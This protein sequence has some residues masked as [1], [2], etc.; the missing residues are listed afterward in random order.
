M[1]IQPRSLCLVLTAGVSLLYGVMAYATSDT[2][3]GGTDGV[4]ATALNWVNNG[5]PGTGDTATFSDAGNGNVM[6][7]LGLGVTLATL[8]FDTADAAAYTI[9]TGAAGSQILRLDNAGAITVNA[10]VINNQLLNAALH[11]TNAAN[12]TATIANNSASLLTF[13]GGVVANVASGNGLLTFTGSGNTAVTQP[14]TKPG[15]GNNA[16]LKHGEGL[17]ALS[18]NTTWSGTGALGRVPSTSGGY[19]LVAREGTLLLNGGAHTVNGELVIGGV[20]VDGGEG[21]HARVIVDN[22]TLNVTG[23]FS[24]GRGNGIGNVSSDLIA[25]NAAIITAVD[26]SAGYNGGNAANRPKGSMTLNDAS[27]LTVTGSLFFLGE[28]DGAEMTLTVNDTA[29]INSNPRMLL[30]CNNAKGTLTM[31]GGT[32]T[33][34]GITIAQG[35]DVTKTG[36]GTVTINAGAFTSSEDVILGY[37]GSNNLGRLTLNGGTFNMG[38][39]ALKWMMIGVNDTSRGQLETSLAAS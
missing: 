9:G 14:V 33:A 10:G 1:R 34:K 22:S 18:A 7:D 25:S 15:G 36:T 29:S 19:P 16:L 30:G 38:T 5:T 32:V 37:S 17:L 31:N 35:N 6:I 20:V 27:S 8:L 4:W 13:A 26:L 39:T 21:Q 12:A 28:S 23:W 11:L 2:W 3:S 24:L